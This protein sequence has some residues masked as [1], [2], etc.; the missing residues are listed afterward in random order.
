MN[1]A[2]E[3]GRGC[4]CVFYAELTPALHRLLMLIFPNPV[5]EEVSLFTGGQAVQK[6]R[7]SEDEEGDVS[8]P[9]GRGM[10]SAVVIS[11]L[12]VFVYVCTCT[13]SL[14]RVPMCLAA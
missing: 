5:V 7:L 12:L 8:L 6:A 10:F 11:K 1:I 4:H 2:W 3:W 14:L 13:V 9:L